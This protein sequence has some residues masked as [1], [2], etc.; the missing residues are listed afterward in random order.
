MAA[1]VSDTD[2]K[3][4]VGADTFVQLFDDDHDGI[5]D[6]E[7]VSTVL[8]DAN[9]L[10]EAHLYRKGYTADQLKKLAQDSLLRRIAADIALGFAG[11]RRV[12]WLDT[13]GKGRYDAMM[14]RGERRLKQI[15]TA[16]LRVPKE[17]KVGGHE[18]MRGDLN[19]GDPALVFAASKADPK[20]PGGF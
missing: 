8:A 17:E 11:E 9:K 13:A 4:R 2:L 16:E 14:V 19:K 15:A 3:N 7:P 12:E 10:V 6:S 20:G 1:F 18:R 5:A